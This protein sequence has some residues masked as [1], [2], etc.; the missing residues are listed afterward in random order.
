MKHRPTF[1]PNLGTSLDEKHGHRHG[2]GCTTI[3]DYEEGL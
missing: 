3:E 1:F 2:H